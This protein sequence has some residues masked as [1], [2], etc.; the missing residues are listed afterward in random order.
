MFSLES[1]WC[2]VPRTS[3]ERDGR[4]SKACKRAEREAR[5]KLMAQP[6]KSHEAAEQISRN[7]ATRTDEHFK[8]IIHASHRLALLHRH[9][10]VFFCKQCGA[11]YA[12]GTL[13]LLKSLYDGTGESRQKTRRKL[14]RGLMPNEQVTADAQPRIFIAAPIF[15]D[16]VGC[17]DSPRIVNFISHK[18]KNLDAQTLRRCRSCPWR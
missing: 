16:D 5:R 6:E 1:S 14:E 12:G 10:N 9:D 17:F 3:A 11:V 2:R 18:K 7:Q 8:G 13:R 15:L 4:Q